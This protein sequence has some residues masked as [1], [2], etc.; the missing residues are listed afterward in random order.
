M[1]PATL[2]EEQHERSC[3]AT[4]R[5]DGKDPEKQEN[6]EGVAARIEVSLVE[7]VKREEEEKASERHRKKDGADSDVKSRRGTRRSGRGRWKR[8]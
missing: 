2:L 6:E 7:P 3:C 5:R 1:L 4:E 8:H